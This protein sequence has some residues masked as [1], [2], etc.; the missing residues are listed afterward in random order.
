MLEKHADQKKLD[1]VVV[2]AKDVLMASDHREYQPTVSNVAYAA[3]VLECFKKGRFV[4]AVQGKEKY[5][6]FKDRAHSLL[7]ASSSSSSTS[8]TPSSSTPS[9][10]LSPNP[11]QRRPQDGVLDSLM[12]EESFRGNEQNGDEEE[13]E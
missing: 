8:S 7:Q 12:D 1:D 9:P 13:I 6:Y 4:S 11:S 5:L 2:L 10:S 3:V